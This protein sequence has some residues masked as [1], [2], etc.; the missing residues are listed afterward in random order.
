MLANFYNLHLENHPHHLARSEKYFILTSHFQHYFSSIQINFKI[1]L[2]NTNSNMQPT[3]N[4]LKLLKTTPVKSKLQ[5]LSLK[6]HIFM[7]RLFT[8]TDIKNTFEL[9]TN[10]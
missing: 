4:Y 1:N 3:M 7:V 8:K 6:C 9:S 5:N 2:P 10:E